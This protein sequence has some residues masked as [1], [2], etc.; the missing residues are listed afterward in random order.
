[1]LPHALFGEPRLGAANTDGAVAEAARADKEAKYS[2]LLHNSRCTLAVV[3][4]EV[5]LVVVVVAVVDV[6]VDNV[7]SYRDLSV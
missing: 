6:E 4:L 7:V 1:M 5:V 2:E 3:A